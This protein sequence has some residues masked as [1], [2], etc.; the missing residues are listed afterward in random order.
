M[1]TASSGRRVTWAARGTGRVPGRRSGHR[2]AGSARGRG[3]PW[4]QASLGRG[5]ERGTGSPGSNSKICQIGGQGVWQG[6]SAL[7]SDPTLEISTL[8]APRIPNTVLIKY[9]PKKT[10]KVCFRSALQPMFPLAPT[11]EDVH[12]CLL[13]LPRWLRIFLQRGRPGFDPG[14]GKIPW[15]KGM[16]THW[17]ILAWRIPWTEEWKTG[18]LQPIGSQRVRHD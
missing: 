2:V 17:S 9:S 7:F 4:P 14:A 8:H 6:E 12:L 18:R 1:R 5:P 15:R 3:E 16:A 13:G 10:Y 11:F